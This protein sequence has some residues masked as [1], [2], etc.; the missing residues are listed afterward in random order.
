MFS[1]LFEI[2]AVIAMQ[3]QSFGDSKNKKDDKTRKDKDNMS[4]ADDV[5]FYKRP[6][7]DEDEDD[8]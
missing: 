8:D 1:K 4:D 6:Y 3:K 7:N 5:P 2:F